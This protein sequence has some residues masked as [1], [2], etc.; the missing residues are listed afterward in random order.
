MC[1]SL[2]RLKYIQHVEV[3]VKMC[4]FTVTAKAAKG[5][6]G[7]AGLDKEA[8]WLAPRSLCTAVKNILLCVY[9]Y[10]CFGNLTIRA[11]MDW[12]P[13]QSRWEKKN[14]GFW[15][16]VGRG[17]HNDL[18]KGG[19]LEFASSTQGCREFASTPRERITLSLLFE[20][21]RIS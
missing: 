12:L 21:L 13:L 14:F 15:E 2:K 3:P 20:A 1:K 10:S 5:F 18:A 19:I 9:I 6:K 11:L 16:D 7:L 17:G 8:V 4:I